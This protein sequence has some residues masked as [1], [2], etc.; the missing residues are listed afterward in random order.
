MPE[1]I[2][3]LA[4]LLVNQKNLLRPSKEDSALLLHQTKEIVKSL[5]S[6]LKKARIKGNIFVG[7]SFAKGTLVKKKPQDVDIFI[8]LRTLTPPIVRRLEQIV[9]RVALKKNARFTKIHGSRDYFHL[10]I[11]SSIFEVVPVKHILK[12]SQ[13]ENVTDLSYF[14]VAY[15]K[16]HLT[17]KMADEVRLAK[18]FCQVS[19]AYGAESYIRG[20]S[21]Y[22]LECL[23]VYYKTFV[24]FLKAIAG[25]KEKLV[26]DPAKQYKNAIEARL[27]LNEA[28]LQ[29]PLVLVDPTYKERNVLA[30][31]SEE[32]FRN[33]Q[34]AARSFI[35]RPKAS[36]FVEKHFDLQEFTRRASKKN[37]KTSLIVLH[38]DRQAGDIAGTK[39][40]KVSSYF[41]ERLSEFFVI[42]D[43]HFSYKGVQEASLFIAYTPRESIERRG[44]LLT[45][46]SASSAFRKHHPHAFVRKGR[47][48]AS[49][50]LTKTLEQ[51]V[52]EILNQR[53]QLYNMGLT[54][55]RVETI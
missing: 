28:K 8:R 7:G 48:W 40:K 13:A 51:T 34:K 22:G 15:M 33:F 47:L 53:E 50:P 6:E 55:I 10:E 42:N 16:K 38:T 5:Q 44:P 30:A 18:Q 43:H 9:Q 36:Y 54:D 2:M 29:S 25:A 20:F 45:M 35:S 26:L 39:L 21:G 4:S 1:R 11:G 37:Q 14:H 32:S 3:T 41:I 19:N 23:I 49:I 24:S 31:L 27:S 46:E 52:R 12:P 17:A